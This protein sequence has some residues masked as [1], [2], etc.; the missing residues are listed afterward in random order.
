MRCSDSCNVWTEPSTSSARVSSS[1][2]GGCAA[3]GSARAHLAGLRASQQHARQVFRDT[4]S[5]PVARRKQLACRAEGGEDNDSVDTAL[6]TSTDSRIKQTLA[7]LDALLGVEEEE[8]RKVEQEEKDK[9]SRE[10]KV[11]S[12]PCTDQVLYPCAFVSSVR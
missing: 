6:K 4:R 2:V 8:Q 11:G 9:K 7:G 1:R 3:P 5:G 10:E 12:Q